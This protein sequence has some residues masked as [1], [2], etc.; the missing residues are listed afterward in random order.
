MNVLKECLII[1]I[2]I[3]SKF[4]C[5]LLLHLF[6]I[7]FHLS[8]ENNHSFF[9]SLFENSHES[10]QVLFSMLRHNA[11]SES[12]LANFYHWILDSVDVNT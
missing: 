7:D 6:L 4:C 12:G 11:D 10:I 3:I 1:N 9:V 5:L 8:F 2:R